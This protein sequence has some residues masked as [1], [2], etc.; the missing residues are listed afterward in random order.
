M[1]EHNIDLGSAYTDG[2]KA[3]REI[4]WC[5]WWIAAF[6]I[7]WATGAFSQTTYTYT[8]SGPALQNGT[9]GSTLD[10]DPYT[11]IVNLSGSVTLAAP[12]AANQA[13]QMANPLSWS[14]GNM[15]SAFLNPGLLAAQPDPVPTLN[16][17]FI[18][19]TVNGVITSWVISVSWNYGGGGDVAGFGTM[20]SIGE[21]GLGTD[22]WVG[23][24]E[25]GISHCGFAN[26]CTSYS[27]Y[28]AQP[29]TWTTPAA[30]LPAPTTP[31]NVG[32]LYCTNGGNVFKVLPAS[33]STSSLVR[34]GTTSAG[35]TCKAPS[36]VASSWYVQI[37]KNGGSTW[38]W[39][40]LSSVGLGE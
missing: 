14:I 31:A 4:P 32:V 17:S 24:P 30:A 27:A 26:A 39:V 13:N 10:P 40:T 5:I 7:L 21:S 34:P 8:Y 12:L 22:S 6:C 28:V 35:Q 37:T 16:A 18:F 1:R 29:G 3:K 2:F 38:S 20:T 25:S 19:S 23:E 11:P 36:G 15:N 33:N 9:W